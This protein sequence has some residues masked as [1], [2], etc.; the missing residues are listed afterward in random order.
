[1]AANNLES[2]LCRQCKTPLVKRYLWAIGAISNNSLEN[3]A[4]FSSQIND[5]EIGLLIGDRYL[6]LT[7]QIFLDTKPGLTPQIPEEIPQEISTYL[8]LFSYSPH[9]PQVYGQLDGYN[10]WLLDYGTVPHDSLGKLDYPQQLVPKI[11][12]FWPQAEAIRQ[13]NWLRQLASL[14]KPLL[15]RKVASTIL[16][17]DLVRVNGSLIQL[18]EL[19]FDAKTPPK[20]QE[21]G[22]LWSQFAKNASPL[23]KQLI[24]TISLRIENG[25]I[26]K[27]EQVLGLLDYSLELCSQNYDYSYQVFACSDSG[28]TRPNNED[29]AYPDNSTPVVIKNQDVSLAIVCDGVGGH[30]GGEIAAK[31]TIHHLRTNIEDMSFSQEHNSPGT[32]FKQLAKFTNKA[33]DAICKRNDNEKRQER[34]RMGTTLVMSLIRN[35]EAYLNS[36]GDS[37][38]YLVTSAGCHQVTIDDDL[39]SR[40]VRLGYAVYRDALQYPSAGALIQ[41]LGMRHSS[42]LHSNVK[43]FIIDDNCVFLLCTDGL[44]DFDRVEQYWR[45]TILPMLNG[46]M[47]IASTV[48]TLVKIANE[49]NGHDNVTVALVHCRIKPKTSKTISPILWSKVETAIE[50]SL[51]WSDV[52]PEILTLPNTE[53]I[54]T[55]P[56]LAES[57]QENF[58]PHRTKQT[59]LLLATFLSVILLVALGFILYSLQSRIEDQGNDLNQPELEQIIPDNED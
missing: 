48:K 57:T 4:T 51:V 8:Q 21:L 39:A 26:E 1:M 50:D 33:N 40:E 16:N 15:E 45:N 56:N 2:S 37:R 9:I 13:L 11:L 42:A 6:A 35:H 41:A 32:I 38:I 44:S 12:S 31:E 5:S 29:A 34:Q 22:R 59:L 30:E 49:K 25:S 17:P 53:F 7:Q 19:E 47:S 52:N 46:K 27:I 10:I 54:A 3:K 18:I 55:E 58:I 24:E 28:P 23:I 20:L 36:V 14:W 43:R